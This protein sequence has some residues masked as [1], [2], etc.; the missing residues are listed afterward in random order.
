[1]KNYLII[2]FDF[3]RATD[4]KQI[5]NEI[6]LEFINNLRKNECKFLNISEQESAHEGLFHSDIPFSL[7]NLFQA[8]STFVT[9]KSTPATDSF[10]ASFYFLSFIRFPI[11]SK[12]NIMQ[13]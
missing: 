11:G 1:M 5:K 8:S 4:I 2:D 13:I 7:K 12:A 3:C 9:I 10:Y 6:E